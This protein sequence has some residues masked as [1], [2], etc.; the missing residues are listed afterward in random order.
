M[1]KNIFWILI[2]CVLISA[3][4]KN[5]WDIYSRIAVVAS[6][7]VVLIEVSLQVIPILKRK[8]IRGIKK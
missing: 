8:M 5:G 3:A 6:S 2:L 4:V 1:K 7:L